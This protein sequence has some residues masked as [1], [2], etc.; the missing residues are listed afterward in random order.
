MEGGMEGR[1]EGWRDGGKEGG[2]EQSTCLCHVAS[3]S[4]SNLDTNRTRLQTQLKRARIIIYT[5]NIVTWWNSC[6]H[7]TVT[8]G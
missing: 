4:L 6:N 1:R 2:I 5:V 7:N 8:Q 3:D